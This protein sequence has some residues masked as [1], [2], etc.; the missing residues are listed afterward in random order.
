M[1]SRLN[2]ALDLIEYG[3]H[4]IPL[5]SVNKDGTCTCGNNCNS[6]GKHPMI[7]DWPNCASRESEQIK[8]WWRRWPD[9]NI[10]IACGSISDLVVLDMDPRH[11][12]ENSLDELENRIGVFTQTTTI[13]TGSGGKH[14]YYRFPGKNLIKN[15]SGKLG[16]GLDIKTDGGYV[17][18]PGSLHK[19]GNTYDWLF[20]INYMVPFPDKLIKELNQQ[21]KQKGVKNDF[22]SL[23]STDPIYEGE[24]NDT[25]FGIGV[26][27][28]NRG[29]SSLQIYHELADINRQRCS[30]PLDIEELKLI[31]SSASKPPNPSNPISQMDSDD[32]CEQDYGLWDTEFG[33]AKEFVDRYS[34]NIR[35]DIDEKQWLI[36]DG[37]RWKADPDEL[38]VTNLSKQLIES[39]YDEAIEMNNEDKQKHAKRS[40]NGTSLNAILNLA[41]TY[42]SVKTSKAELD[43]HPLKVT[44]ENLTFDFHVNAKIKPAP[45]H[46]ITKKLPF[47][48]SSTA[49]APLWENFIDQIMGGK[50]DMIDFLQQA[51]G[52]TLTGLT[53]EQCLFF[54]YGSG[55]NGKSTFIEILLK[56]FGE[57]SIKADS[58]MIMDRRNG[59]I[60][61]DIAR[62]CGH[63]LVVLSEIQEG[64]QLDEAK[65]KNITGGDTISARFLRKEFFDFIPTHKLWVFG[66]HKPLINGTDEGIWRRLYLI[67]FGVTI[68][69]K[70]VDPNLKDKLLNELPG[71]FNWA[72]EGC[73][74]W[75][76]N[77]QKLQIPGDVKR[78]TLAY[79]GEMDILSTFLDE[80]CNQDPLFTCSNKD[81]RNAYEEWCSNS[82][83][84]PISPQKLN[85]KLEQRGF[86]KYK[87][88]GC[89]QW[90]GL[91][92][93]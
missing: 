24:R 15:S 54:L 86:E 79:R 69:K 31:A 57:Y 71:I 66:N 46:L 48:Y 68:P 16:E 1:N 45:K 62:L 65:V 41:K 8:K 42:Y 80:S 36:W 26:S 77:G 60:P 75:I 14:F 6:E 20:D 70:E 52:Y 13:T 39:L 56:L 17:V 50:Q 63:R 88:N 85:P 34:N 51:V 67:N 58:E 19:S 61:N 3:F 33:N 91:E 28:R 64:R 89:V 25:L 72:L 47:S 43:Q 92:P 37:I 49:E 10:G 18:A 74:K 81:L 27:L 82:G 55:R 84:F 30:P 12:G 35:Y 78:D 21:S 87:S 11:N 7:Q 83:M 44:M 22:H 90:R 93:K 23:Q 40:A 29:L 2:E 32:S 4:L 73:R 9:A 38:N 53:T 5:H 76:E 59:G